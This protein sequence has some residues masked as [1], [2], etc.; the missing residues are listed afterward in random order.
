MSEKSIRQDFPIHW[1]VWH[2]EFRSL[3]QELSKNDTEIH[4]EKLDPRGRTPLHLSV[5]LGHI[6]SARVL[7]R[8]GA[9][10]NAENKQNWTVLQEAVS[11][12]DPELVQLILQHRDFQRFTTRT[13]GIPGLLETL[14]EAP[15]FYVE[16]RWEF[17]SWVPLVSRMCPSDT[18][19]V[20]KSGANVRIDTTLLGFDNMSWQ[21]GSRSFI[22]RG[23]HNEATV[24]EVDHD[25]RQVYTETMRVLP[26]PPDPTALTPSEDAVVSRLTSPIVTTYLDTHKIAFERNKTGI[27]GWRSDK[28]ENVNG[29]E[30][31]VFSATNVE[32]LTKTRT[33][34]L[35][36]E[37][38]KETKKLSR[39]P[40][41]SFLG[42]A[43]IENSKAQGAT[44]GDVTTQS[45]NP[46]SISPLEYFNSMIDLQGKDI[47]RPKEQSVKVQKFKATLSLCESFP[48]SLQEQVVPIIDIM[49]QN[50]AHFK[51]LKDFITLTLPAGFPVKIEIPLFHVLNAKITFGN[52]YANTEAVPGVTSIKDTSP[53][54]CVVDE[55]MFDVP[56]GYVIQGEGHMD[57]RYQDEDDALLQFAIQQSLLE[58]GSENDQVTFYEALMKS[59]PG[60]TAGYKTLEERQ[61][62]RALAASL[63][64]S[65]QPGESLSQDSV[66]EE[67][68][69]R[70]YPRTQPEDPMDQQLRLALEM[71]QKQQAEDERRR[72][73][74]DEELQRILQ[75]SMTEK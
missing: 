58:S 64:I 10:A 65:H 11:T 56:P 25:I 32:V 47:G 17:A 63:S 54:T 42:M 2:N 23:Q 74:E 35:T 55:S 24:M 38:K 50:N 60:P 19:K 14:K 18:Y 1:L 4:L 5:T 28:V 49:A 20:Y 15:D 46:C 61:L 75:L 44:N 7:L 69:C 52:I 68:I 48:L 16:M 67:D 73:Q 13:E 33:E 59:P 39:T 8:K 12:G 51:K 70:P 41:E 29:Y 6:E 66:P 34:H 22:F 36:E 71:S 37:D 45:N 3:D 57:N 21:R 43:E 27:W 62:Q 72:M 30:C 26:S 53:M 40:L 9:N 31:K